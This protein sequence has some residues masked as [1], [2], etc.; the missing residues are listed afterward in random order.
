MIDGPGSEAAYL[1]HR[2]ALSEP[3]QL[4]FEWHDLQELKES[5]C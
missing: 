2:E 1:V 3:V 4:E 5:A